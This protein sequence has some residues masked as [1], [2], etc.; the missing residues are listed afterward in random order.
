MFFIRIFELFFLV[1]KRL[2]F[3]RQTSEKK[4]IIKKFNFFEKKIYLYLEGNKKML[5]F[6]K[7]NKTDNKTD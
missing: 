4:K 1:K 2:N 5:T 6:A 7:N 3:Y